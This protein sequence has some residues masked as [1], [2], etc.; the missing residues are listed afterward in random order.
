MKKL[1]FFAV[2]IL[3]FTAVSFGQTGVNATATAS[4]TIVGPIA[5]ANQADLNFG[6]L[7][8]NGGVAGT[9]SLTDDITTVLSTTGGVVAVAG[10]D[11]LSCAQFLVSG[12]VGYAYSITQPVDVTLTGPSSSMLLT[13]TTL[14]ASKTISATAAQNVLYVGGSLAVAGDQGAGLYKNESDLKVTVNYN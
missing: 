4:A 3:G 5:I 2:V 10:G 12:T 7:A 9:A 1:L 8:V 6:N 13:L 11:A 14:P